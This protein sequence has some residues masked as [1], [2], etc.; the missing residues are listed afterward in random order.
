M[1]KGGIERCTCG[2]IKREHYQASANTNKK[3]SR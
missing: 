1:N 2:H 3:G